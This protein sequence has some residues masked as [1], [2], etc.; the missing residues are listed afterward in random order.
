MSYRFTLR[1]LEYAVALADTLNFRKAAERCN[2][3]QPSLSVQLAQLEDAIGTRLFERDRR[4]VLLTPRGAEV[5]AL[6]RSVLREAEHLETL[7]RNAADP[8]AGT[9]RIGII[10]TLA[11]YLLPRISKALR[12]EYPRLSFLWSEERTDGLVRLLSAGTL[13]AI[14]AAKEAFLGDVEDE[15]VLRDPFVIAAART[16]PIVKTDRLARTAELK[17]HEVLLLEDGHCLRDQVLTVCSRARAHEL[18]FRATSLTTLVQMIGDGSALTLLPEISVGVEGKG[19][20][21]RRFAD[22]APHRTIVLAWRKGSPLRDAFRHLAATMRNT[23][24]R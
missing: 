15:I 12:R 4:R 2:V 6:S 1:Q 5:I 7:L 14:L 16:H 21:L 9:M 18:E 19:L 11:P 13:D 8:F 23:L 22:P 3:S 10:P 20:A 24:E 17:G